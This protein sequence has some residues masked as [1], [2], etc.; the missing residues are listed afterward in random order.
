M[1][2]EIP[3][4]AGDLAKARAKACAELDLAAEGVRSQYLTEGAGQALTYM[5][6]EQEARGLL[7]GSSSPTPI[8]VKEAAAT[9]VA[10]ADLALTIVAMADE[11]VLKAADIEAA[12]LG[13][14]ASIRAAGTSAAIEAAALAAQAALRAL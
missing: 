6:K 8:L 11:W 3:A 13:G 7:A 4:E 9:G 14:K 12:R 10:I 1:A 2:F 5:R